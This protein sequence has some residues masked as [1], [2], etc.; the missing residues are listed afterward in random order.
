MAMRTEQYGN[1]FAKLNYGNLS[2][3]AVRNL[4]GS[5][6]GQMRPRVPPD[7]RLLRSLR[8]GVRPPSSHRSLAALSLGN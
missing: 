6:T 1:L 5:R 7:T 2:D 8:Q 4:R 3:C